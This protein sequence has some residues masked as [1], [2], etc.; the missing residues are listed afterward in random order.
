MT[1]FVLGVVGLGSAL[2]LATSFHG[3]RIQWLRVA[4]CAM[5]LAMAWALTEPN[6][7]GTFQDDGGWV[8]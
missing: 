8:R 3:K 4:F 5:A 1:G 7:P 2:G 6:P